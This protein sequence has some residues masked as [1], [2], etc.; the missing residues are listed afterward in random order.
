VLEHVPNSLVEIG[1]TDLNA[2]TRKYTD[3]IAFYQ[4]QY[5]GRVQFS[6]TPEVETHHPNTLRFLYEPSL[7]ADF[8]Y[9]GDIDIL[10]LARDVL[11]SHLTYM[12]LNQ[13]SYSNVVRKN[14]NPKRLTGLHF[15][16]YDQMYP[17]PT[18]KDVEDKINDEAYLYMLMD[19]KGLKAPSPQV[20]YRPIHGIHCSLN[21]PIFDSTPI[22]KISNGGLKWSVDAW[23]DS[24]IAFSK[25]PAFKHFFATL[26][27]KKHLCLIKLLEDIELA[28]FF[29]N[30][31]HPWRFFSRLKRK[32]KRYRMYQGNHLS[33]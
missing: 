21:R 26:D 16:A 1:V 27:A 24:Y 32:I 13:L 23:T 2:F 14:S 33:I 18:M 25:H 31:T 30:K 12:Q 6:E 17:L 15:C 4:R 22:S 9:I 10:L 28:C 8:V 20:E 29:H 7:K 5:P 19:K 11:S 3:S